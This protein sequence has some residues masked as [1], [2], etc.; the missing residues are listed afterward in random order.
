MP[1]PVPAVPVIEVPVEEFKEITEN[2]GED[3]FLGQGDSGKVYFGVLRSGRGAAIR[4]L[5]WEESEE[6][7][8]AEVKFDHGGSVVIDLGL[9]QIY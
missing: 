3:S 2:F 1:A 6:E 8:L 4:T 7:F 5:H 9:N